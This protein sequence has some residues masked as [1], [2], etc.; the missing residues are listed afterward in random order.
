[1]LSFCVCFHETVQAAYLLARNRTVRSDP[2]MN[3]ASYHTVDNNYRVFIILLL[4]E[5]AAFV[6]CANTDVLFVD[7]K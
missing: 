2:A 6:T 4:N 1:M 5:Y 3:P 7:Q